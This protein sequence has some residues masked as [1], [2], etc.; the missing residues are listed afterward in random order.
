M[1]DHARTYKAGAAT[2]DMSHGN[3]TGNVT[4][5]SPG[6]GRPSP[7]A[8]V[9]NRIEIL[10]QKAAAM[11]GL[12]E[13]RLGGVQVPEGDKAASDRIVEVGVTAV[14]GQD[15]PPAF[16]EMMTRLN[17]LAYELDALRG[18]LARVSV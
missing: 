17:S 18:H 3:I 4:F 15:M 5:P 2:F 10:I 12:A 6:P 1:D 11:N 9:V 7:G 8:E 13:E 14:I 16:Q